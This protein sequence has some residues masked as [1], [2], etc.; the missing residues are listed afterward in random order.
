MALE[1]RSAGALKSTDGVAP[2][3]S[4]APRINSWLSRLANI[5]VVRI[6]TT[7]NDRAASVFVMAV[8]P[9]GMSYVSSEYYEVES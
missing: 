4:R 9:F 5:F 7:R 3:V 8:D 2:P 1:L 6:R